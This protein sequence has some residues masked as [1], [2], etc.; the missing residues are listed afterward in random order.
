MQTIIDE[1]F[2]FYSDNMN[3]FIFNGLD[4]AVMP[5][6]AGK[7]EYYEVFAKLDIASA[8]TYEVIADGVGHETDCRFTGVMMEF[9]RFGYLNNIGSF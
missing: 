8:V 7:V 9:I 4:D 3:W 5:P 6:Q 1:N 2:A